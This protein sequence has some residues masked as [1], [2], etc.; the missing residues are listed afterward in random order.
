MKRLWNPMDRLVM[1]SKGAIARVSCAGGAPG[2]RP[3]S[4]NAMD[5]HLRGS[6]RSSLHWHTGR[7][8]KPSG[9]KALSAVH[10]PVAR[11]G[12]LKGMQR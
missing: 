12:G 3:W 7:S 4:W 10:V 1:T 11:T 6:S 2:H 8:D 5:T 9:K